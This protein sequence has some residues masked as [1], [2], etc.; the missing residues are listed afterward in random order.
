MT[1]SPL[2][3]LAGVFTLVLG[4]AH[5]FFP[6]LLDFR[7]A[8][9]LEGAPLRPFRLAFIRYP[10]RRR[11]VCGIA[12]VMNHSVSYA[13]IC[14]GAF[15]LAGA[16]QAPWLTAPAGRLVCG[17]IAGWWFIRAASQLYLGRRRGDWLLLALF[18][19]LGILHAV[20]AVR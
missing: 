16:A 17:W 19:G 1:I 9:P 7:G 2:L 8:I 12:W 20:A 5:V 10:T 15:D 4:V 3:V 14:I 6:V 11:D 13:L 18:A